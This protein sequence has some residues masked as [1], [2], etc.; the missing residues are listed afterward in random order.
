MKILGISTGHDSGASLVYDGILKV[1]INEERLSRRKLHI[2][3]PIKSIKKVLELSNTKISEIDI[4][5]I[6][7]K[8]ID[9]QNFGEEF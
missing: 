8:K 1:S 9:P 2:G 5:A 4:I 7:G 6:E 3:F